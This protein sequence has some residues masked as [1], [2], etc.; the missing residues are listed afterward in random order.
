VTKGPFAQT[1][2]LVAGYWIWEVKD[3]DEAITWV[4]RCPNPMYTESEIEIR[5]VFTAEDFGDQLTPELRAQEERLQK[6]LD[7]KK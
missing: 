1:S 7:A 4:K 2:E 3:L 6:E 5:R